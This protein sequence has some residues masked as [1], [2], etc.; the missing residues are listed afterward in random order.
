MEERS[1]SRAAFRLNLPQPTISAALARLRRAL[2]DK[3]LVRGRKE[4]V[5]TECALDIYERARSA[6]DC[7]ESMCAHPARTDHANKNRSVALATFDYIGPDLI[8]AAVAEILTA[9]PFVTV[10]VHNLSVDL[11]YVAALESGH[12]D[13]VV[14]NWGE[15]PGHLKRRSLFSDDVVCV[16]RKAHPLVKSGLT[17]ESYSLAEHVGLIPHHVDRL[18]VIDAYL[19]KQGIQREF[20]A[21][22]PTFNGIAQLLVRSDC[23]FTTCR[24]FANGHARGLPLAVI[25]APIS[26]PAMNFYLLWHERSQNSVQ[27]RAVR[28]AVA[29]GVKK[30]LNLI[31]GEA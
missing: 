9:L 28:N 1:A 30:S 7:M 24:S 17:H 26:F 2:G 10:Q 11:D 5:P 31:T 19:A 13:L 27:S 15:P 16:L 20:R 3:L 22:L 29:R 25:D 4:M 21:I 18:G 12:L 14:G 6:L 8:P 23:V